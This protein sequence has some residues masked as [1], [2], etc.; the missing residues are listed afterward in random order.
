MLFGLICFS[1][2]AKTSQ[3]LPKTNP[4]HQLSKAGKM[5]SNPEETLSSDAGLHGETTDFGLCAPDPSARLAI[6]P[7][8]LPWDG[9]ARDVLKDR[10]PPFF[11]D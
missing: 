3:Y 5:T 4:A 6:A 9:S 8:P 11:P 2:Q 10:S 7:V 1:T